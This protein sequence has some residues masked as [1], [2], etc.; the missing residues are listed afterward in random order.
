MSPDGRAWSPTGSPASRVAIPD[1]G[2]WPEA[3]GRGRRGV[4]S[5][6]S[7]ARRGRIAGSWACSKGS[8]RR[9]STF[10]VG[11]SRDPAMGSG[12]TAY[13][14]LHGVAQHAMYHAGQIMILK[15]LATRP[16]A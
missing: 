14:N 9:T 7:R 3:A 2:E 16:M 6:E 8:T 12:M 1:G 13:A 5:R 10:A 15:K 4:G 11:E